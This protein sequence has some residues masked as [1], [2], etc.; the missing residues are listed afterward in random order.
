MSKMKAHPTYITVTKGGSGWTAV[1]M[2]W[3]QDIP[4]NGGYDVQ[5][6]GMESFKTRKPAE[7]EG[8]YWA[9]DEGLRFKR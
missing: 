2:R 5:Q 9:K 7:R 8:R 6:S 1:M 4:P 3:Y